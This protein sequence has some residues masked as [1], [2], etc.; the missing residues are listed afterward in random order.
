MLVS[1]RILIQNGRRTHVV[2]DWRVVSI[3]EEDASRTDILRLYTG[4]CE[5]SYDALEPFS[6]PSESRNAPV[7]ALIGRAQNAMDFQD[8][9]LNVC[10]ADAVSLFG[11][12]IKFIIMLDLLKFHAIAAGTRSR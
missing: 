10:V 5:H 3:P 12:Y 8:V 7:R 4:I 9:P 6:P 11:V 1:T 2:R